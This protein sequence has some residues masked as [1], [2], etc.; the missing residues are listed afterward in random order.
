VRAATGEIPPGVADGATLRIRGKGESGVRGGADGDLYVR[1]DVEPHALFDRRGDDLV[2]ALDIPLTQAVL[3]A[4]IPVQTLD[5][6]EEI[7]VPAGT[8]HGTVLRLRGKGIP[9]LNGH[10]R[11]DLL[12]H[13]SVAIPGK[14]KAEERALFE[15]LATLRGESVNADKG[16]G[17][18]RRMRDSFLGE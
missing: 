15:K 14:L 13:V 10:G 11:G 8:Q 5:D 9:H 4:T 12:I 6:D 1:V 17:V 7:S 2:C 16:K 18:F 3:G